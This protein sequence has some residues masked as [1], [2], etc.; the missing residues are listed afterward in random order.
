VQFQQGPGHQQ[1]KYFVG[2]LEKRNAKRKRSRYLKMAAAA[3]AK[4]QR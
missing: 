1:G 2:H 3:A 4:T